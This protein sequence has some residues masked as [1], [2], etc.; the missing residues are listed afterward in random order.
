M[1]LLILDTADKVAEW[2]AKYVLKRIN[3][4]NPGP[5]KYFVLGLPT[6]STPLGMYKK[7]IEFHNAGKISF[8]YVKTFN[9]DEYVDLPRDHPESYHY[10]MW[11]NFFKHIDIN[12]ANVHILDG[13]ASD[14]QKECD[15][16]ERKITEAGGI[17]LFI[18][19]I[20]PD[21]HIAFN[22]PGSSL[23]SRTRVKTL[24]QDTLEANARFFGNDMSKVPKQALT[25]GVGTVMDAKE[26]MILITGTHKAFALYKAIEEGVNHMWTVS[27]FQQHRHTI[28][29]CDE[30]ATL[31]LRVKTVKYFKNLWN[32]HSKLIDGPWSDFSG[33]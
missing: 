20:G 5:D 6:G 27:A 15:E 31:E 13:N 32:V 16:F 17:E 24:A 29:L 12:P 30:D 2:S 18:G 21:G 33:N 7:L 26:V 23:V 22:E 10:Y 14:L 4:F 1:K 8:K 19:G 11:N 25:V 28:F 9:M 3:D